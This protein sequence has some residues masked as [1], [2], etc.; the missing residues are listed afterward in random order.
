MP[1]RVHAACSYSSLELTAHPGE[2]I[3][4]PKLAERSNLSN[5]PRRRPMSETH[6][7]TPF[8]VEEQQ[9][10]AV[11]LMGRPA[12]LPRKLVCTAYICDLTTPSS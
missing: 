4:V 1:Q 6:L 7:L 5:L 2:H 9:L 10:L 12:A 3:D 11:S 8:D